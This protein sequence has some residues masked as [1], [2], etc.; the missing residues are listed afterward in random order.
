MAAYHLSL[1]QSEYWMYNARFLLAAF[2][3]RSAACAVNDICDSKFD[4]GVERTKD[5]PLPSG[6]ISVFS[7][8]MFLCCVYLVAICSFLS[9][10]T[11]AFYAA[12]F[13]L[14]PL[15]GAYP[16]MKRV[17]YWPQAYLG[18]VVCFPNI[19]VWAAMTEEPYWKLVGVAMVGVWC[20]AVQFDTIYACMDRKDDVKVGVKSSA[21]ILGDYVVPFTMGCAAL[22]IGMFAYIGVLNEHTAIYYIITVGGATVHVIWQYATLDVNNVASCM[23]IGLSNIP[24]G[25]LVWS[26]I[27]L[28]YLVKIDAIQLGFKLPF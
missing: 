6:R 23:S 8:I 19:T 12:V 25:M 17:T 3:I 21:V 4:G 5:R 13:H 9:F 7:A 22:F 20:W 16:L 27:L 2:C 11:I 14:I 18:L 24:L 1:P 15:F 26:G 28:D 10:N